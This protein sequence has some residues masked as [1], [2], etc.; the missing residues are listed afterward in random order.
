MNEKLW[1]GFDNFELVRKK[2]LSAYDIVLSG[3]VNPDG[4]SIGSLL[5]LGLGLES[6]GKKVYMVSQDGVPGRYRRLPGANRIMRNFDKAV[7]LAI[8]VDCGDK[9]ILGK[10]FHAFRKAKDILEIDHHE[11]RVPFG[12]M[13]LIDPKAA[14]VGEIIYLFL[15]ALAVPITAEIAQNILTSI[16]VETSSF[17]LPNVRALT[18]EICAKLI[19]Q[20][21]DFYELVKTV[22]WSRRREEVLL[23]GLCL[24]RCQFLKKDRLVW[25]IVKKRDFDSVKGKDEDVD[26]VADDMRAIQGVEIAI[27][28]RERKNNKIRVSLRSKGKINIAAIAEKYGGGG[29]FDVA[30]CYIPNKESI[31]KEVLASALTLL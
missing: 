7:D 15:N 23:S 18:F 31:K 22:F 8:S 24:E 16:I 10:T 1:D 3:H 25:S 5:A 30:G 20:R 11:F 17:R 4:D 9:K 2:I 6:L 28:F 21:A 29:H 14:A 12:T 26:A 27:L 19:N 13:S